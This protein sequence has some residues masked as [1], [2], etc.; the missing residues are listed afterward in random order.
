MLRV[1]HLPV[2]CSLTL[3]RFR[4]A[5]YC[6]YPQYAPLVWSLGLI[7]ANMYWMPVSYFVYLYLPIYTC[8]YRATWLYIYH[9]VSFFLILYQN[10]HRQFVLNLYES[11]GFLPFVVFLTSFFLQSLDCLFMHGASSNK[12]Q[13]FSR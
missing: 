4:H 5:F 12:G 1:C 7:H 10:L 6:H 8:L 2:C 3:F 11:L 9:V 13:L